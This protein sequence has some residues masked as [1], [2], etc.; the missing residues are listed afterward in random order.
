MRRRANGEGSIWQRNSDGRWVVQFSIPNQPKP[1]VKY[2]KSE[3]EAVATLHALIVAAKT[4]TY[5]PPSNITL[6]EYLRDW[7]IENIEGNVSANWYA[8]KM[9]MICLHI[10]PEIGHK[11]MQKIKTRDVKEFYKMLAK[12]GNKSK[13]KKQDEQIGLASGSIRHIHNILKPA[14]MQ[15]VEDGI[16]GYKQNPMKKVKAPRVTRKTKPKTLDEAD[17]HKY[18]AQLV[19]HRLYAAFVLNLGTGLRRGELLGL[20][21]TD[22]DIAT[23]VLTVKTQLQRV[24]QEGGGSKLEITE[25]LKTDG[26]ARSMVLASCVLDEIKFHLGR[27]E[28][29]KQKAGSLYND[30]GLLFCGRLGNKLDP[31]RPYELHCRALKKAEL[32]HIR[33][34]DLRH[35]FAT[36]L[37]EKGEDIKTI[38]E[39]LG[40]K[41]IGTTLNTYAHV[42]QKMKAA[43]AARVENILADPLKQ[44]PGT[45]EPNDNAN[46]TADPEKPR[47]RLVAENG[48]IVNPK[49]MSERKIM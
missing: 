19:D 24:Q 9:D 14:F 35:T 6:S 8:R 25:V 2:C 48:R 43:S 1:I 23:G 4:D 10:D 3:D 38:Q 7:M 45:R 27:Q 41:D 30:E 40:H 49:K 22:I 21:R 28:I 12:S 16:I 13:H 36:L 18:L 44:L 39:L 5:I 15:A 34:H 11:E 17:I 37:L 31:R 33:L 32:E 26:S 42:T 20:H 46:L 47:L 29:E